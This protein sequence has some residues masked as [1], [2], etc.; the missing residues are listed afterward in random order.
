MKMVRMM[1]SRMTKTLRSFTRLLSAGPKGNQVMIFIENH[2]LVAF[3]ASRQEPIFKTEGSEGHPA[4][5]L[6]YELSKVKL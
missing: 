6:L 2:D 5:V 4:E 3:G 1:T